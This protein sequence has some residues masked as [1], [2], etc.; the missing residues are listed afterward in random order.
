MESYRKTVEVLSENNNEIALEVINRSPMIMRIE[1]NLRY[2][3]FKDSER[4]NSRL[5]AIYLDI[6]NEL[7]RM[8]QHLVSI[9]QVQIGIV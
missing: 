4:M 2:H 1:K 3:H 6:I 8:N 5:S 9:S 7:L